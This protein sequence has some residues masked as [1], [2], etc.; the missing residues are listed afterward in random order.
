[1]RSGISSNLP[2]DF[3]ENSVTI[4]P[5]LVV[6]D[7]AVLPRMFKDLNTIRSL[8]R[9]D[10]YILFNYDDSD[11]QHAIF[12]AGTNPSNDMFENRRLGAARIYG[13]P[14]R[15]AFYDLLKVNPNLN[16]DFYGDSVPI[17]TSILGRIANSYIEIMDYSGSSEIIHQVTPTY[18]YTNKTLDYSLVSALDLENIK[19]FIQSGIN[20]NPLN[21][22]IWFNPD[23]SINSTV[24][25]KLFLYEG[26]DANL[27]A[28]ESFFEMS[29]DLTVSSL[30]S[31][32]SNSYE[33]SQ[34][35]TIEAG[36]KILVSYTEDGITLSQTV[37]NIDEDKI[38][39][40][41]SNTGDTSD[42]S[43]IHI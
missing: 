14:A 23:S 4:N 9:G 33:S 31:G 27:D 20:G 7:I 13:Q 36:A 15:T 6:K 8:F 42:L 10:D 5:E 29:F 37:V 43:L 38:T 3:V 2:Y 21:A 34:L 17:N 41:D 22:K 26:E 40:T 32:N 24:P 12:E 25:I 39:L 30:A 19:D 18:D 16:I 1:M 11:G 35:W 28:N